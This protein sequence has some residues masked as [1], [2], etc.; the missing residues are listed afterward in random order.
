M[1]DIVVTCDVTHAPIGAL[2]AS[3][4]ENSSD[5]SVTW[6]TS[7]E[8][9]TPYVLP[10][11]SFEAAKFGQEPFGVS[12]KHVPTAVFRAAFVVGEKADAAL[13]KRNIHKE[14][15]FLYISMLFIV[16]YFFLKQFSKALEILFFIFS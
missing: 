12:V 8:P 9:I 7:Q 5:I 15:I 6:D 2:N 10:V 11:S 1:A 13:I 3:A 16:L 14:F 4:K